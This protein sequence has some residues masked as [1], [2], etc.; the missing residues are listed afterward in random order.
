MKLSGQGQARVGGTLEQPDEGGRV[1]VLL[2]MMRTA[3]PVAL[4]RSAL[5]PAA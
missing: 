3:V 4:H 2:D 1:R 5:S